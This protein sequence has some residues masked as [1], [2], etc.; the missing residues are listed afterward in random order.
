MQ[1]S[2][3][4][5]SNATITADVYLS[6]KRTSSRAS[7]ISGSLERNAR[8]TSRVPHRSYIL[9][10]NGISLLS[11]ILVVMIAVLAVGI[12]L[13]LLIAAIIVVCCLRSR[14]AKGSISG[15]PSFLR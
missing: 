5:A 13:I 11:L 2:A 7:A 8:S 15:G 12:F 3:K 4:T 6:Q 10:L 14:R 1:K 9:K